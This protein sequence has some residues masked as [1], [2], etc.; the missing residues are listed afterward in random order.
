MKT[1]LRILDGTDK[2]ATQRRLS[3][4]DLNGLMA[5][6]V[7]KVVTKV[8]PMPKKR[9]VVAASASAVTKKCKLS[10]INWKESSICAC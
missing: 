8:P 5:P 4:E 6:N 3:L 1:I 2:M 9:K 10:G 7:T